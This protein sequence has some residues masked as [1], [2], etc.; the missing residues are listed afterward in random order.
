MRVTRLFLQ[1]S[2]YNRADVV[3]PLSLFCIITLPSNASRCSSHHRKQHS[4]SRSPI[5]SIISLNTSPTSSPRSSPFESRMASDTA[6]RPSGNTTSGSADKVDTRTRRSR[7]RLCASPGAE[8]LVNNEM[9]EVKQSWPIDGEF[10]LAL[11]VSVLYARR[12]C[13]VVS[14][15]STEFCIYRSFSITGENKHYTAKRTSR[16][17][18]M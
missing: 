18:R 4:F 16:R 7:C 2:F 11:F 1:P 9:R 10:S 15:P 5:F 14:F 6:F 12:S 8:R 17:H 13:G 3:F